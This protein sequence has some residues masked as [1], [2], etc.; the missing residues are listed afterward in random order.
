MAEDYTAKRRDLATKAIEAATRAV[1]AIQYLA[2]VGPE[3]A[4]TGGGFEDSDFEGTALAHVN[5]WKMNNLVNVVAVGL[6]AA[7]DTPLPGSDVTFKEILLAVK[8][9]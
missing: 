1:E 3:L 9:A 2:N 6:R 4:Q 8:R 5:A 7:S